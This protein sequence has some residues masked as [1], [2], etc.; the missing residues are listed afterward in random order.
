MSGQEPAFS[1]RLWLWFCTQVLLGDGT[2]AGRCLLSGLSLS[3]K[4]RPQVEGGHLGCIFSS[5]LLDPAGVPG[6]FLREGAF[7]EM[8]RDF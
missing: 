4:L 2:R 3:G 8:D 7:S 5:G 1:P 6:D